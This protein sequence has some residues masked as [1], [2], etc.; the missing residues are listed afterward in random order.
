MKA[1]ITLGMVFAVMTASAH[2]L[3]KKKSVEKKQDV[4]LEYEC[5][6]MTY[7]EIREQLREGAITLEE[8]QTLWLE[9]KKNEQ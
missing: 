9:H 8:A 2:P 6:R 7:D 5:C 1:I 4:H 3:S